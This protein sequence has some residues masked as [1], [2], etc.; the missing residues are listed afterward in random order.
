MHFRASASLAVSV[1]ALVVLPVACQAGGLVHFCSDA[2]AASCGCDC[3]CDD[4][5][6][7]KHESDCD[8]DPCGSI[9]IRPE[10]EAELPDPALISAYDLPPTFLGKLPSVLGRLVV[11]SFLPRPDIP[12]PPSDRPLLI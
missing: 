2:C 12:F 7:C 1:W 3:D 6:A 10:D 8:S 11:V 5:C 9:V 4:G